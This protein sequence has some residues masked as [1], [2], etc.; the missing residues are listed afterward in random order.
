MTPPT[1]SFV[2]SAA[3]Q[4]D[5]HPADV[6]ALKTQSLKSY[7]L[8]RQ[9][10]PIKAGTEPKEDWNGNYVFA[11]IKESITARAMTSRWV[12]SSSH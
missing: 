12:C 4:A 11:E 5:F 6:K 1:A 8:P 2:S 3:P 7:S 10:Y 9:S